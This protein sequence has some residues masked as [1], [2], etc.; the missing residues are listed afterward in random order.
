[1]SWA[2]PK[3]GIIHSRLDDADVHELTH[4]AEFWVSGRSLSCS[5]I[6][7]GFANYMAMPK[8]EC[9]GLAK[10]L[11]MKKQLPPLTELETLFGKA[12]SYATIATTSASFVAYLV[13]A[14]GAQKFVSIFQRSWRT[15]ADIFQTVYGS[16]TELMDKGWRDYLRSYS[17]ADDKPEIKSDPPTILLKAYPTGTWVVRGGDGEERTYT[18]SKNVNVYYE[19]GKVS[20]KVTMD[21]VGGF[22]L[23]FDN[24]ASERWLLNKQHGTCNV[25]FGYHHG[26]SH[27]GTA[28]ATRIRD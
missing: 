8:K 16:T 9:I 24:G 12:K 10:G 22:M 26:R 2:Q 11:L 15:P 17:L 14:G 20:G 25:T 23:A 19:E 27:G 3:D 7:Q 21:R 6:H 28:V 1:L 5:V 18:F 4:V 13:D